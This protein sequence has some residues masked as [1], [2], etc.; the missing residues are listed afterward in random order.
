MTQPEFSS[1]PISRAASVIHWLV[2]LEVCWVLASLPGLLL[3]LLL[4]PVASNIPL[5]AL[6]LI[7]LGPATGAALYAWRAFGE[8][9]DPEPARHFLRGYR[10]CVWDV[11]RWW[12]PTL[13][14]LTLLGINLTNLDAVTGPP[15]VR[16]L[17]GAV[18]AAVGLGL[19][20]ASGHAVVISSLYNLRTRD[21]ARLSIYYL[22][23]KPMASIG[24][25]VLVAIVAGAA[26]G[27][28]DWLPVL[29]AAPLIWLLLRGERPV[30]DH[31]EENFING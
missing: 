8:D 3:L 28:S 31:L 23:A 26:L 18:S 9:A 17:L 30:R 7:P 19:L 27:V 20:V 1:R 16:T 11:L 25:A 4:L 29:A 13:A 5:M 15:A 6:A 22:T 12:V 10:R 24:V 14:A 21:V 2:V